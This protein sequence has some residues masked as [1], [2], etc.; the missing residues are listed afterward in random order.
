MSAIPKRKLCWHCEGNI[1]LEEENCPYC[2]VYTHSAENNTFGSNQDNPFAPAYKFPETD[3]SNSLEQTQ[4]E[5]V[6]VQSDQLHDWISFLKPLFYLLLGSTLGIFGCV[7][8]LFNNNGVFTL[9]WNADIWYLYLSFSLPL[10]WLG[11]RSLSSADSD[12]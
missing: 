7:L 2:G 3:L 12:E 11:I 10:L 6:P 9:Q 5:E 8:L 4:E 1:T